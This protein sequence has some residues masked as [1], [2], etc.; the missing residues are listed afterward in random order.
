MNYFILFLV[1]L[2][3]LVLIFHSF[4][5]NNKN[6]IIN[7]N[8]NVEN[9]NFCD[10]L[11]I[12]NSSIKNNDIKYIDEIFNSSQIFINN[13]RLTIEYIN[14]IRNIREK[15]YYLKEDNYKTKN[16]EQLN[17]NI[18]K[19]NL[20]YFQKKEEKFNYKD[21]G[22]ICVEEK[23]IDKKKKKK[24]IP[25][26]SVIVPCF[27]KFNIIM[28]SIRSIQNQ[29]F[30]DI[31]IIIVDDYSTD[32]SSLYYN[33]LLESDSRIRIFKHLQNM[34]VWRTRLDGF[35]YSRGKYIIHFD[36]GDL[37]A[38]PYVLE[39]AYGLIEKYKLDSVKMM[40]T[41]IYNYSNIEHS[42][43]PFKINSDYTKLVYGSCKIKEYNFE[44]FSTWGNI[45]TRLTK[46]NIVSKGLKLLDSKILNIYKNLWEDCWWNRIIDEVSYTFL[47]VNRN[48]YLYYKDGNG[49]GDIKVENDFQKNKIIIEFLNFL[50]FDLKLLPKENNKNEI[51]KKLRHYSKSKEMNINFLTS[52]FDILNDLLIIL[53]NDPFVSNIK[54]VFLKR[55]LNE[56]KNK[57]NI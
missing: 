25:I 47:V 42:S 23:L 51:I 52:N 48:S 16:N 46:A 2:I 1:F 56:F 26:I 53:I 20:D 33:Y 39:D 12:I 8:I 21:Y 15:E 45:W 24:Y 57:N 44:I 41:L 19:F 28:R 6:Y 10:L 3:N 14:Y 17:K 32:N 4:I 22:K 49:E 38:D 31:E 54:K 18:I 37:Y 7:D 34:G 43:I 27:N 29:S 30:K 35:L 11:P 5:F 55:L 40:F 13:K 50:Y 36:A 9:Q